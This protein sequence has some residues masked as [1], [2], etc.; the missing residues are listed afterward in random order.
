MLRMPS[1]ITGFTLCMAAFSWSA[2]YAGDDIV[3]RDAW[4]RAPVLEGRPAAGYFVIEN[5]GERAHV[6]TGAAADAAERVELHTHIRDGDR[7]MMRP[8]DSV[9]VSA[10]ETFTFK[11][12]G[13]H[14]MIFG[15][16]SVTPGDSVSLTLTFADHDPVR[17]EA[18][19]VAP[20]SSAPDFGED[21]SG[22]KTGDDD[23]HDDHGHHH[24]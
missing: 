4:V 8:V 23:A 15:V 21:A 24:H 18:R 17:T 12:H 6:L 11:P 1:V 19:V 7:M 13:H 9:D 16:E 20:G 3:V 2:A 22:N 5:R 14:L 10:G